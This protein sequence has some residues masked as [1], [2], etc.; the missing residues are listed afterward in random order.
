M[1]GGTATGD[2]VFATAKGTTVAGSYI[3]DITTP[4]S[5]A[6][7]GLMFDGGA[8]TD[9]R[10]GVRVG[11]I[12]ATV[13]VVAGQT[14]T[15]I[16][17]NLNAALADAGLDVVAQSDG[18]G[19]RL[20]AGA[21]GAAGNFELNPD[22]LGAGAW[23]TLTGT[24]VVGTIDG[25]AATGTGRRL[26]LASD[27]AT[28]AAGLGVDVAGGATGAI[29]NVEYVPGLAAR[30]V[31]VTSAL[32]RADTG[33]INS[34]KTSAESRADA[35]GDQIARLEDRLITREANMRRQWASL[36]TLLSGLQNQGSWLSGQLSSLSNNWGAA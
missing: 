31:A 23:S 32:T 28:P 10:V 20:V 14:A 33:L 1:R 4:A 26:V 30:V 9:T 16:I 19:V 7:S 25:V 5:R 12:T 2:V 13:D 22:L 36:Q 27:A 8:A 34:A 3:V 24:D 18:T 11:T 6:A 17:Q 29:G 35:F 21:W 15:Q